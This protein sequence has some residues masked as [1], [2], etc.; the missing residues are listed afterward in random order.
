VPSYLGSCDVHT[1]PIRF[2]LGA[3]DV[4]IRL[5]DYTVHE[6]ADVL[7]RYLRGL[8]CPVMTSELYG[9]WLAAI[10]KSLCDIILSTALMLC[11][12]IST[13]CYL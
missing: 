11:M 8:Q 12:G 5:E 7:K 2:P 13:S 9:Q 10:S 4:H 1:H 6:V 3:R